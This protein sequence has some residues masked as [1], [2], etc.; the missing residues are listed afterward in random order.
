MRSEQGTEVGN[1]CLAHSGQGGQSQPWGGS[2]TPAGHWGQLRSCSASPQRDSASQEQTLCLKQ[3][4]LGF[5]WHWDHGEQVGGTQVCPKGGTLAAL[6]CATRTQIKSQCSTKLPLPK[7]NPSVP[8]NLPFPNLI[9]M[10]HQTSP[11][12]QGFLLSS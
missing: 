7:L 12:Q 2:V 11:S 4:P 3:L 6:L 10:S 1:H 9:P 8:P 5:C